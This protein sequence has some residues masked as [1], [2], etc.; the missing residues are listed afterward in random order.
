MP[1]VVASNLQIVRG[2][3]AHACQ[4]AGRKT[5]DVTL[6]AVSKRQDLELVKLA[7]GAGQVD[8]GE[9][10]VQ[11][12]LARIDALG[13]EGIRWHLIGNLQSKKGKQAIAAS[14]I[15]GIGS[16][17]AANAVSRAQV[18]Q[19][20]A[21]SRSVFVQVNISQEAS[22]SGLDA[23]AVE[24]VLLQMQELPCL[25]IRGL[26]CIPEQGHGRK[27][28]ADLRELAGTLRKT[29]GLSLPDLSMGM[30]GD[31]EDAILEGATMVRVGRAIFGDRAT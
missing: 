30:S 27:G 28:F 31:Y 17:K 19:E 3:I 7:Q 14:V 2:R 5:E 6:I 1:E 22:K 8:F 25:E 21:H 12:L 9:N 10:L 23:G 15:H 26:M 24:E 20:A 13:S 16:L 4:S 18:Q 11:S 29:T